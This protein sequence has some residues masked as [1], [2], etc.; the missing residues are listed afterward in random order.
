MEVRSIKVCDVKVQLSF[1]RMRYWGY[2][3]ILDY[4]NR[5]L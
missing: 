2:A 3:R 1:F 5:G 4:V